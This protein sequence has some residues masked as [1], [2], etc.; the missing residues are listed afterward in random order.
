MKYRVVSVLKDNRPRFLIISDIEEIE[1]LPSKYLKHLD[2]INA[3]PNTVKSAAFALSY[4]YNYL[5]EQTIG[6]DEITLLSYSEQNKHFIDFLYW[7]KSGKHTE[8]NTQTSNKTCNMY[9]GAVFRYYQFLALEDVLPML[10]V[11]RVKKVSYFDSMGVNHQNAVNLVACVLM[12]K[13]SLLAD[14]YSPYEQR[15]V[16]ISTSSIALQK[17]IL[18]EYIPFLSRILQENG[19]IQAPLKAVIR[20]G[21]EHFVCDERLAQRIVAIKEKNKNALQKEA[22][23]SL[24]EHY[25]MDEVSGLS[26]FDRR[27]VSVPK[28]C[29]KE[30]PKKGSCRYQQ[31]LEHSRDDE[32]FIQICNHN[33]LLADGYHRLQDYRP[34]LKD[35]RALIVDEAHKL[36]DAAKQMFGKSLCYDDIQEICFY[37]GKEY[38]GPEIRKLS[39]TIRMVLDVIGENHRTRYGLKEEFHMTEEYAMYLYEGIQTMNKII[40][41]LEKK[42]PKWIRNK[43]E[44]TR[45]VLECFFHQDQK[46]VLHLKQDQEHR[47]ILCA[48]SRRIPQY[49]DQM[50]WSRGMGAILTSGTL[51]T[52]QGFAHIR[53]MIGLQKVQRVREYVADSPFEYQR[54]CLLYL[55]KDLKRCRRGSQEETE[56]IADHIHSLICSTYGHTLVLFTSYHLMGNVYQMLRDEIPFPMIEVW[57]HSPEEITRF[58]QTDNAVLFAAGSCWEGVDFPGDM[59]S[60]LIIVKLPFAVPDPISEAQKKEYDCLKD[61][62]QAVVV[63]D[64]QKKLRQGF[65]RALRTET[66]TCVVSILDERAGEE[67]RYHE[68]VM[69]ALPKC[70]MTKDIKD[71][72]RFI[73]NRKGV[74]YYL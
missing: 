26:G 56:M 17:A 24:R 14:G 57:R 53:K 60:S 19:T 38:Q 42:I 21:K 49:L 73:R 16:V 13:Y 29:S 18:T 39:G 45:S 36:P 32:M 12:R 4:Y 28:F 68:E 8:H 35:Y 25:D 71:V 44:E 52:G 51:K 69:C 74:E 66:D 46:Y 65:G 3:S 70:K 40:E 27:M 11:L 9:L 54:N 48:S 64:M 67:G 62:I 37:L 30:C 2:Q 5:Q 58:K 59:V 47:I 41:K 50:L 31:Y 22:L 72:Q 55:P 1:I 7:V 23:L 15:P 34:L 6:L 61:Y 20:K 63:P 43:L 33:Y 10:K